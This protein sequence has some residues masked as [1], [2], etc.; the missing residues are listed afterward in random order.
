MS[1]LAA[2]M[3]EYKQRSRRFRND[4]LEAQKHAPEEARE[5][6]EMAAETVRDAIGY[7]RRLGD[8]DP[9]ALDLAPEDEVEIARQLADCWGMLG[10]VYRAAGELSNAKDAYD[11]GA[12]YEKSPRFRILNTYNQVNRLVVRIL[13]QPDLLSPAG[14]VVTDLPERRDVPMR[15]L[16]REMADEIERQLHEGRPDR[17][18]ALADL[19]MVRVL[20]ELEGVGAALAAL[21]ESSANDTFPYESTLKVVRELMTRRLHVHDQL[22]SVGAQLQSRLPPDAQGEPIQP[23]TQA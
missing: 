9:R 23:V 20:G 4:A 13:E 11:T 5:Q 21:D 12:V 19:L 16:L 10:G 3:D 2:R 18:W 1:V 14:D 8:P 7:L 6:F 22:V 15:A 17:P